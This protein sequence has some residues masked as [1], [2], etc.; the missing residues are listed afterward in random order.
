MYESEILGVYQECNIR[1]FPIDCNAIVRRLGFTLV[2]YKELAENNEEYRRLC[3][4][5]SDA[6][7]WY[8]DQLMICYNHRINRR[9]IRFSIMHEVGH[10]ILQ[11]NNE[12]EADNFAAGILAPPAIILDRKI[13]DAEKVSRYFDISI[14]AANHAVMESH[15]YNQSDGGRIAGYFRS[16]MLDNDIFSYPIRPAAK[17]GIRTERERQFYERELWLAENYAGF[18]EMAF[19]N[20]D[21][22]AFF[23]F[24]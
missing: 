2:S 10:Y 5:S 22:D 17:K 12:D 13:C 7:T 24:G 20:R 21:L 18:A 6:F 14:T 1:K 19:I 16:F 4:Y 3:L 15:T 23:P 8:G 11:T 9:R